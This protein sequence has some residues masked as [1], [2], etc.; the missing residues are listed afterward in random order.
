MEFEKLP[1][2]SQNLLNYNNSDNNNQ[3]NTKQRRLLNDM[4]NMHSY[5]AYQSFKPVRTT[6][7]TTPCSETIL[8]ALS[9]LVIAILF[10]IAVF[11]CLITVKEYERVVILRLGRLR[12]RGMFGPGVVFVLPCIDEY[13]KVD[14]RTKAFDVEP[15][16]IL[17]KDSVTIA[18]DAVVYYS[19][20]NPLDSVLQVSNVTESTR[21]LAQ[22]TLRNVIGTKNLMEMLTAKETLSKTIEQILDEATDAWGVKVERVEM[23]DLRLPTSMQRAMAAEAEAL[24]EAK[25]KIVAAEGELN[26]S[27][28][29][30]QA[31][32]VMA[33]NPMTLQLRYLQ[34]MSTISSEKNSTIV[35][36]FPLDFYAQ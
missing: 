34:T 23:T 8:I 7:E 30:R 5:N 1:R 27:R 36:P 14:M 9:Y 10:P 19:I 24:R 16:E 4:R 21:L 3:N 35:F 12:K 33:S 29:L 13:H 15:Q 31:S 20:R 11:C 22:T 17:T 18:V 25:A 2:S 28:A 26:A 32:D 6:T